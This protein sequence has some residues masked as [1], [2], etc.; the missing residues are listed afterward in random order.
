MELTYY[1]NKLYNFIINLEWDY[2]EINK[3]FINEKLNN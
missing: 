3:Y 2:Y 1:I